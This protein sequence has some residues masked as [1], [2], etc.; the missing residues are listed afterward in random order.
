MVVVVMSDEN[1]IGLWQQGVIGLAQAGVKV[2]VFA[3]PFDTDGGV[4]KQSKDDV[5]SAVAISAILY[6]V[7]FHNSCCLKSNV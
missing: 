1:C 3:I 4:A 7:G 2:D 5:T 6:E